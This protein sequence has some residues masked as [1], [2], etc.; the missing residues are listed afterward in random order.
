[1]GSAA[2]LARVC[3]E[4]LGRFRQAVLVE[5]YLPG[6]EFTVGVLGTG[7][8]AEALPVME[9]LLKVKAQKG[10]YSYE[11]KQNYRE[12]VDYRLIDGELAGLCADVS[13]RAW[14][15]LGCRDAGRVDLRLDE[16]GAPNFIEV[17]PLAG[18]NPVDSD[19]PIMCRLIGRP[20]EALI[21]DIVRSAIDRIGHARRG[22]P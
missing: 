18:L 19:L 14:R 9:I 6:R 21:G 13:L 7:K 2:E 5:R 17:N 12:V 8:K 3:L 10:A 1:V 11:N 15:C 22:T 20:Y 16:R 4:L